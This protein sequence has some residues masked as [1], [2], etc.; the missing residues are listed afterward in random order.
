MK[1]ITHKDNLNNQET[2][3]IIEMPDKVEVSLVQANELKHYELFQWL[4]IFFLPIAAGFWT[5]YFTLNKPPELFWSAL[6][7]TAASGL[8]IFL[9]LEYRKKVFH[10]SIR[11]V[12]HLNSFE[13][14]QRV[15]GLIKKE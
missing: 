4:L 7:F 13:D 5:A 9:S 6:V 1:K 14:E 8:F 15:K 2:K 10:K 3:I 11:K 12:A